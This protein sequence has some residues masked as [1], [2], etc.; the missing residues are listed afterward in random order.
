MRQRTG[1]S[2][3]PERSLRISSGVPNDSRRSNI[4]QAYVLDSEQRS[5]LIHGEDMLDGTT[6]LFPAAYA[7]VDAGYT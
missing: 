1:S 2:V 7:V 4:S 6:G 3:S 5:G